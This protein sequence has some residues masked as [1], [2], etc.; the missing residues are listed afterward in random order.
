MA[1]GR[2]DPPVAIAGADVAAWVGDTGVLRDDFAPVDQL[3]G[4][5]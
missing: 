2:D 3:L 4:D 5:R 1:G